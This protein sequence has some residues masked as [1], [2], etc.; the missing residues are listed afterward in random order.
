MFYSRNGQFKLDE[1]RNLTNM[2][3]MQ[4]TGYPATGTPPTIQQGANPVGLTIPNTLMPAKV[5]T[6][7]SMV[8]NLNSSDKTIEAGVAFNPTNADSYN[9]RAASRY[10][11]PRVTPMT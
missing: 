6:T 10:S 9:K 11:I 3:G 5:T 1:S 2:Q 8:V 7:A 4:V